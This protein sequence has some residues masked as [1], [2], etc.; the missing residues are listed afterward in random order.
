MK[1]CIKKMKTQRKIIFIALFVIANI[2]YSQT[3]TVLAKSDKSPVLFAH[4]VFKPINSETK[5]QVVLTDTNGTVTIPASILNLRSQILISC[6]GYEKLMDTLILNTNKI[7]YLKE[8]NQV[9][10]EVV[11]TGQ[12]APNS[13]E[14]AVH[15]IKIIDRKKID[16]MG[17]QNLR[18]VL[19]NEM[20]IRISQD[21]ILG[22]SMSLQ[23]VSGE[24]VKILIDGVPVIGRLGGNIDLSQINLNNIERIE[25]IEGPMSVSYGTNALAGTINLIT[26]KSQLNT[27]ETTINSYYESIGHYN[28]TGK[29]GFNKNKN[30]F[31]VSGGRNFCDGWKDGDKISFINNKPQLADSNR[32]Q[33]WKPKEQYFGDL[34]YIR[35]INKLSLNYKGGYFYEKI[36]NRG[37]PRSPYGETAFDDYYRTYR[38]DNAVFLNGEIAK[39]KNLNF[40]ISYNDYKRIKNEYYKDLTTLSEVLTENQS[41]QDTTKFNLINSRATFSTSKDSAKINYEVGYDINVENAY[42]LRIKDKQQQIGDYALF[43]SAEYKPIEPLTIRPGLRYAYNTVYQAP[44]VPSLNVRYKIKN[45]ITLRACY[46]K[47]FRAPSLKDLYFYF[48]DINHN[49]KGNENLKAEYSDNYSLTAN[50]SKIKE[51]RIYKIETSVYYNDIRNLIT[52]AQTTGSEYSYVNIGKYKTLGIQLNHEIAINHL[53]ISLGGSYTGRYNILSETQ[54]VEPFSYTPEVR[55]NVMYEFKK[56]NLT[57]ALFYKYTGKLPGFTVDANNNI[58]PTFI[59]EYHTADLSVSKLLWKKRINLTVGSKNLFNVKNVPAFASGSGHSSSTSSVPIGTG[60][61]YFIKLDFNLH[62]TK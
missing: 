60:R 1:Q 5:E 2:S 45:N 62:S 57:T 28:L 31:T 46:A 33:Q 56:I 53:K 29:V 59:N 39:N 9:L 15:K 54:N 32:Y 26:K 10:N 27:I 34:Q 3:I 52:L 20:N 48:V 8:Q 12:Y 19:T 6:I 38:I 24:N 40:L 47:G 50:Y 17:A 4:V 18:D 37:Y 7:Y 22:S 44:L 16:A 23:G 51:N 61:T 21:N 49:I 55:S 13:P 30:K 58:S 25:V 41:D 35:K 11:V 36:S 43:S 14:K 42:G